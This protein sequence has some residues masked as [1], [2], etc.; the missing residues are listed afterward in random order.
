MDNKL[1]TRALVAVQAL[2]LLTALWGFSTTALANPGLVKDVNEGPEGSEVF[3]TYSGNANAQSGIMPLGN[4]KAIVLLKNGSQLGL[5]VTDGTSAGTSRLMEMPAETRLITSPH[6]IN[7]VR[8]FWLGAT[9]GSD[10]IMLPRLWRSDGTV[11]GTYELRSA[12]GKL[13]YGVGSIAR[14]GNKLIF[15]ANETGVG[16]SSLWVSDGSEPGT[17]KLAPYCSE[18]DATYGGPSLSDF[19]SDG[20]NGYQYFG[21]TACTSAGHELWRT[22]GTDEGT[23]R[24]AQIS[25]STNGLPPIFLKFAGEQVFFRGYTD[26]TGFEL[27]VSDGSEAGT[28]M[29]ANLVADAGHGRPI[30]LKA[31]GNKVLFSATSDAFA[32]EYWVSDGTELGTMPLTELGDFDTD[33]YIGWATEVGDLVYFTATADG[34]TTEMLM[35]T[36]GTVAGTTRIK[37]VD[38]VGYYTAVGDKIFMQ[39]R[40]GNA[41]AELW[42]TDGTETGTTLAKDIFAGANSSSPH[43]LVA[44]S[45]TKLLFLANDGSNGTEPWLYDTTIVPPPPASDG[46]SGGGGGGSMPILLMLI[47]LLFARHRRRS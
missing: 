29:V 27:W 18:V 17:V 28:R 16:A 37:T 40:T 8:Y 33:G 13:L 23:E 14:L 10:P 32:R 35:R 20:L 5:Y 7:G 36:D 26:E 30:P 31:I 15:A 19:D 41:G 44:L 34:G 47:P 3:Q 11:S 21:V 12:D 22:D 42:L 9:P 43:N 4:G 6:T 46:D 1:S 24:V 45:D 39:A 2:P 38:R 25:A